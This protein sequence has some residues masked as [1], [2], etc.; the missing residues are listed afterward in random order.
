MQKSK[1]LL[2]VLLFTI[3][4]LIVGVLIWSFFNPYARVMLI[5]LGMLSLYY[6]LIYG[7]V[8]LTN[9][10]ESRMYYYFILVLII[11]PLLTLG[12]AYDRFIAFSVSLLNYLQQ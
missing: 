2:A 9:Q 4:I 5:P 12:L 1:K 3:L 7:F 6:L 11:I 8:S 10:S